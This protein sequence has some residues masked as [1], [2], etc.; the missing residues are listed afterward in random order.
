MDDLPA[1]ARIALDGNRRRGDLHGLGDVADWKI[2]VNALAR[3]HGGA[4]LRRLQFLETRRLSDH[5]ITAHS[6]FEELIVAQIVGG[7]DLARAGVNIGQRDASVRNRTAP[8]IRG[9][10]KNTS[11]FKLAKQKPGAGEKGQRRTERSSQPELPWVLH[12]RH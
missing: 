4:K 6:H 8:G 3:A 12:I 1:I 7:G 2:H 9:G 10:T 11:G 5:A